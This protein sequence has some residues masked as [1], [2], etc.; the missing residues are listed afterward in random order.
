MALDSDR[1]AVSRRES[2]FAAGALYFALPLSASA[3]TFEEFMAKKQKKERQEQIAKQVWY[4]GHEEDD[5]FFGS[6]SLAVV[7]F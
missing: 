1:A 7:L 2:L 5:E 3:D 4:F 6:S